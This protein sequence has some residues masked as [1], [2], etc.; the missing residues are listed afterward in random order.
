MLTR[1]SLYLLLGVALV[2]CRGDRVR[3]TETESE[4]RI[5]EEGLAE[6]VGMSSERLSIAVDSFRRAVDDGRVTGAQLLVARQGKV[7]V[8]EALGWRSLQPRLP[9]ERSTLI[10]MASNTKSVVATGV[11]M[12]WEDGQLELSDYV[13]EYLPG[14]DDGLSAQL[15]I[16]DLLRHTTGF[17]NQ[18]DNYV[19]EI[20]THSAEYL[21][22]PSLKVEAV[23]IGEEGPAIA[24]GR[25][26]QYNNWGYTVL[27]AIIEEVAGQKVDRFLSERIYEPIGMTETSHTLWGVDSTRVA[28]NYMKDF[29]DWE[30]LPPESP[31]FVRTTGGL[32]STAWDFAKF[33]LL[34]LNGGSYDGSRLL[35]PETIAAATSLQ[36]E[37]PYQYGTPETMEATGLKADW[38]VTRDSRGLDLDIGYGY[39]WAIARNGAFSH[40]GFRG[41][42]AY[43]DPKED[44]IILIFAQSRAGGIPGQAFIDAVYD[45]I[46]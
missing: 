6:E 8:H 27:G 17:S 35:K 11:L 32:V 5:L 44:L 36:A 9:M 1:F 19:G 30:V 40:S 28:V 16:C 26:F 13:A 18:L 33:C 45:A 23:K 29:G 4:T 12:L 25:Q 39:G 21:E 38:P 37:G 2:Q 7:I 31:P 15:T 10:R 24:P 46:Q 34:F 20:T 41:T 42:F 43:I 14:F 3:D 22:A